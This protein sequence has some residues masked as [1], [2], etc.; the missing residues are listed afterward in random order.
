MKSQMMFRALVLLAALGS[1]GAV[2]RG[3]A[4]H[5]TEASPACDIPR[6]E[7]FAS[8]QSFSE[9]EQ[10]RTQLQALSRRH[11]YVLQVRWVEALCGTRATGASGIPTGL[12]GVSQ[13]ISELEERISE[14]R[15]TGEEPVLTNGL[16]ILLAGAGSYERW[17]DVYLDLLYRRPT[18]DAVGRL[19]DAAVMAGRATGRLEEVLEGF[20][21]LSRIP[22]DFECKRRVQAA[23]AGHTPMGVPLTPSLSRSEGKRV[24]AGRVRGIFT[25]EGRAE[26]AWFME[27]RRALP[28]PPDANT[29]G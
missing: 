19:A 24:P 6:L 27:N 11:L 28:Q 15:G 2:L 23:L 17:L 21:H 18:E 22:F 12:E 1:V 4:P 10:A 14:F 9:V 5:G 26:G 25:V 8:A 3:L 29:N 7:Y 20:R 16:L 13:L